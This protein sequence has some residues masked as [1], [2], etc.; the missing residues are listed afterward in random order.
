MKRALIALALVAAAI[1]AL[2]ADVRIT[3]KT[4]TDSMMMMGQ[5]VPAKDVDSEVWIGGTRMATATKDNAFI[6]NLDKGVVYLV[7]HTNQSY[8]EAPL[9]LDFAKILPPEA[10]PM[11][12]MMQMTAT[13]TPIA[14]KKKIGEWDCSGYDATLGIMGMTMKMRIWATTQV[15]FDLNQFL[16]KM[17]P[18]VV[19]GQMRMGD[20]A[21]AEF[22]KI[23]GYQIAT[24]TTGEM[25]GAS[26]RTTTEVVKMVQATAP[27][28][29]FEPPAGYTKRTTL[30]MDELRR[31]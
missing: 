14:E 20:A 6:I 9:P 19:Q 3:V 10:A 23:K 21:V 12:S 8:V 27:A 18:A 28:G 2:A 22:A 17:M 30:G 1:P 15:P 11:A 13:V 26:I 7:N 5:N 16:S 31:R 4:H 24:E 25:M 29:T